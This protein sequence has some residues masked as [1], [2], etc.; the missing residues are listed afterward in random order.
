MQQRFPIAS[1]TPS[2][3]A[4]DKVEVVA[5]IVRV[6]LRPTPSLSSLYRLRAYEPQNSKSVYAPAFGPS[7]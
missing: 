5:D 4:V 7:P 1:L 3:F 6:R 2:G